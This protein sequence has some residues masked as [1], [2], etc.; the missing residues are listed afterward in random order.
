MHKSADLMCVCFF[1]FFKLT[2]NIFEVGTFSNEE[3]E[4]NQLIKLIIRF[5]RGDKHKF[6]FSLL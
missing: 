6:K 1:F 5:K 2:D 3:A 4:L